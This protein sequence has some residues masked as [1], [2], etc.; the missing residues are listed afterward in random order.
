MTT[1]SFRRK[2]K[3]TLS[4]SKLSSL[5][6]LHLACKIP[7]A[8]KS[9]KLRIWTFRSVATCEHSFESA[10]SAPWALGNAVYFFVI[11]QAR[12]VFTAFRDLGRQ[13]FSLAGPHTRWESLSPSL[14]N[15]LGINLSPPKFWRPECQY[16]WLAA[17]KGPSTALFG[18][19]TLGS[20]WLE[21]HRSN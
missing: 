21:T 3:W 15:L 18:R 12:C 5:N 17:F 8:V 11:L 10:I 19:G 7:F 14:R 20:T 6:C 1:R 2:W 9:S 16:D 4:F 13:E